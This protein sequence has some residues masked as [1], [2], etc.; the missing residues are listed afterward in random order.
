[1]AAKKKTPSSLQNV[2]APLPARYRTNDFDLS[3]VTP[4][5]VRSILRNV[6]TGRL[7]DQD[8]LFRL[9][10][11]TWYRLRKNLNEVAGAVARLPVEIMAPIREGE[12]EPSARAQ[13][14]TAIVKRALESYAPAPQAWELDK[15]GAI[16]A[17]IDAYGKGISVLEVIWHVQN[18]IIS[19]RCYAPTP[20]KYLSYP[21]DGNQVDRLMLA[22][23]GVNNSVLEDFPEDRFLIGVWQQGGT[24]PIH[25]ANLRSLTK[26]W[27]G[28]V[29][30]MGWLMQY[31][32]LFAI[33]WR[34][35]ET[36]GSDQAMMRA[37]EM[38]ESIGSSGYAVTGEGVKLNIVEGVSG[39]ASAMPQSHL[40]D[41]ADRACD[42]LFL[43][44]T[45]TSD[46]GDSGSRA[47]G[48]V[49]EGIRVEIIQ[50]VASWVANIF[51]N[52]L[53]PSIVRLNFG[54]VPAEDMPYAK[55]V[56][57]EKQ[58]QKAQAERMKIIKEIG[59]E[60]PREYAYE[61]LQIPMPTDGEK[62]V[63]D[64]AQIA[65]P[66]M[67]ELIPTEDMAEAAQLALQVRREK[68]KSERG[69]TAA[70]LSKARDIADRK[71]LTKV[72]ASRML[73]FFEEA[74]KNRDDD[75][76]NAQGA[77]WQEWHAYGG[78]YGYEFVK[79][80]TASWK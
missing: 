23:D 25:C 66:P 64:P 61:T 36:D 47:L 60:V 10:I 58:D 67:D 15:E 32:Q 1:M 37:E 49:H 35:V 65:P 51:T 79:R 20:A 17:L 31:A 24:H 22:K 71:P 21:T 63:G 5:Q 75:D 11:D 55:I 9:M 57:P 77:S 70:M 54:Y 18:G 28:A 40:M 78:D 46:V 4:E 42:I 76:F 3:N 29:Y 14:I 56:I 45:L 2:V 72:M 53:I 7:E 62:I 41:V 68:P 33:P 48:D 80:A 43:G 38:L 44:Q 59:I 26:H 12:T 27:L 69:M 39:S 74:Q 13:Q 19:P 16:K 8:R 52:Q 30:G 34:H 73:S 50:S 6:R